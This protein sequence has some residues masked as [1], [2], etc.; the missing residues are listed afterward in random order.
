[1]GPLRIAVN[2]SPRQLQHDDLVGQVARVLAETGLAPG[3]LELEFTETALLLEDEAIGDAIHRLR[4]LGVGLALD[5]F[6]TG[7]SSLAHL[8][9]YP[10][11]RLKMDRS[12]V[13]G[14]TG[15]RG[16]AA[17]ARAI[18]GLARELRLAVVAE[19]VETAEQLALLGSFGCEEAQGFHLGRPMPAH[20]VA[21]AYR[22]AA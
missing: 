22:I 16:D 10:I 21:G 1:M 20:A 18:I 19:G 2:V 13:R 6:G 14:I 4:D 15:D 7:Y 3:R 17:V 12:F 5:D 9:Q 11:Q 8:R